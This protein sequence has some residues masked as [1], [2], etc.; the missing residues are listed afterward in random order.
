MTQAICP[1][2]MKYFHSF[3]E[4]R[5]RFNDVRDYQHLLAVFRNTQAVEAVKSRQRHSE[6]EDLGRM[7]DELFVDI[8]SIV[9]E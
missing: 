1:A 6:L 3:L 5:Y 4:S 7:V 9:E 2:E 8:D